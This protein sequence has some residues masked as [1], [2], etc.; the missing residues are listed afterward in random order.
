[1]DEDTFAFGPFRLIPAQRIV[2][3]PAIGGQPLG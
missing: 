2:E 1:V 3:M